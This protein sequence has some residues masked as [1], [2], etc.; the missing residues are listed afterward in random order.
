[1]LSNAVCSP[2][3]GVEEISDVENNLII[4]PN[5]SQNIFTITLKNNFIKEVE[6]INESGQT[7]FRK[8]NINNSQYLLDIGNSV[9]G[10][11]FLKVTDDK[12]TILYRKIILKK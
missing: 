5:P 11:F 2:I 9:N 7:I 1:L 12:K 6:M 4:F 8:E 10:I 3:L